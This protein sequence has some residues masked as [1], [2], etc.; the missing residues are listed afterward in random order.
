[1]TQEEAVSKVVSLACEQIGYKEGQN[2]WNK[3]AE[4]PMVTKAIGWYAQNQPWCS[5]FQVW[6]FINA[7][8]YDNG[9]SMMYGCSAG[10]ANQASYYQSHG[11]FY[12]SPQK[13]DQIFFYYG[14]AINHTGIVVDVSGSTV[15]TVEGNYSDGIYEN[16]YFIGDDA[17]IAGYGRPDWSVVADE[18]PDDPDEPVEEV[19]AYPTIRYG[20]GLKPNRPLN[21]VKAWQCILLSWGYDLGPDGADGEFGSYTLTRTQSLQRRVGI[22]A[23][24]IVGEET[25]KQGIYMPVK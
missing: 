10:C 22:E 11:A 9:V 6:L 18:D 2:N 24:G 19:R 17:M 25:W 12:S 21:T 4:D 1:M 15:T 3:Y 16:T 7:F 8:G 5:I 14:G 20:D 13:G 23:D